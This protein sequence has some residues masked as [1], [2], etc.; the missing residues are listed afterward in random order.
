MFVSRPFLRLAAALVALAPVAP[1]AAVDKLVNTPAEK[2]VTAPGGV[3][4]RTGRFVYEEQDLSI[5]G[6]GNA[7]LSFSRTLTATV[8]G[9]INPFGNLSHN[10]DIMVS[11]R[12]FSIDNPD[13][14]SGQDF[15]INVH[16]GGRSMTY[17]A[18]PTT[19]GY[20]QMS[21]GTPAPLTFT[22]DRAGAAVYTYTAADGTVAVFRPIGTGECS[23]AR[24]CAYVSEITEVD[25]TR[26]TFAYVSAGVGMRLTRVTSSRGFALLL[27]GSGPLVTKACLLNLAVTSAPASGLCPAGVPSATYSYTGDNRIAAA[28]GPD[29]ATSSFQYG[30]AAYL[31]QMAGSSTTGFVKPGYTTPWLTN[32]SH[33]RI[34]EIGV[35]Q[36]IVDHQAYADGQTYTYQYQ[37]SPW[38]SYKEQALAG[39]TYVDALGEGGTAEYAWPI[40]PGANYPGSTCWHKPCVEPMPDGPIDD[41]S[42]VYHQTPGPVMISGQ[43][44]ATQFQFCDAAAMAGLPGNERNRCVVDPVAQYIIDQDGVRI[45]LKYDDNYNVIE[46]KRSPKPG[47]LNQDGTAPAPIVTS[48]TYVT[49]LSKAVNKPL[50]MT[51][52]RGNTSRWTYAPEHGGVRTE[53]G[54]EVNGVAPQKRYDYVQRTARLADASAAG[55]AVWLLDRM[56]T[57]RTGKPAL[58]GPG[59]ALGASD[60]VVTRY[61]YGPETGPNNLLLRGQSVTADGTTLRT[62][63]AY[64]GQGRKISE[65]SP[66]GTA[67]L[68]ACPMAAPAGPLPFTS[69]TRYDVDGKVTGT[70]APDPDGSGPLPSPAVRNS[71]D[72]AGRLIMVEEGMLAGWLPH[73]VQPSAWTGFAVLK[74][75]VSRYDALDR[76]TREWVNAGGATWSST[77]YSYDLAGR[78]KCTAVRMNPDAW[79]VPLADP[80]VHGPAHA[81]HGRDRISKNVYD[82]AGRLSEVWDGVGTPLQRREAAWTYNGHQKLSL[83]DARG[84]RAEMKYDGFGRQQRWVF[85]SKTT[86]GVADA[87]DYE[88]Y[89]Y[90][91]TG[92]RTS[93]RKRDG[94]VLTF[95]YDALNRMIAKIVP[96]RAGLTAAQTRDVHYEYDLRGLQT[97]ARFDSLAGE[98]VTTQYDGFGRST[99]STLAM[100]GTSRAIGHLYDANGNRTRITHPDGGWLAYEYDGLERFKLL[101]E[102]SGD[103]LVSFTYDAAGRRSGLASGGTASAY[104][105][106]PAGRL[107]SLSHNLAGTS[108]DQV[109]GLGYNP[110][111]QIVT[112]TGS[113]D[114]FAWN[115]AV[116]V[117]RP[118][119]VNGQNQYIAAG[120]AGFTYDANGN[121]TSDGSTT[122]VYDVENRLVSASG[123]K[124]AALVYDP[125]GRLF[126]TSGGA[127]GIAQFLYD[128]DA[129]IAEYNSAGTMLRRYVHGAGK[130]V[131]DPLLWYENLASGWR[132]ALVADQQG[133][134][135][136][137][138]DM[139]GNP[140]AFNAYDEYGV[141][142]PDQNGTP[143]AGNTGRFQYTGQAWIPEL[144]MYYYKARIYSPTLGRFLQVDPIGYDDQINLYVYVGNDPINKFDPAGTEGKSWWTSVTEWAGDAWSDLKTEARRIP[145]DLRSLPR[146]I[147]NGTTGLPP[148]VSGG[149]NIATAPIRAVNAVR[150]GLAARTAVAIER[151][152]ASI[153]VQAGKNSVTFKTVGGF[154][155]V[156]LAGKAHY[157][158]EL[159]RMVSTPHVQAFRENIV[160]GVVKSISRVGEAVPAT[161]RDLERVAEALK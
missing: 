136:A 13:S 116:A 12:K 106:D 95:Q 21:P 99:S 70:I 2:F 112:R 57:C 17:Q 4:L 140:I 86:A 158:K 53:T 78:L 160:N 138:A 73:G 148:T 94:S 16:F 24:R 14:P 56:S 26:F 71:Y 101:R 110:A 38:L 51:D 82:T 40:A 48:A 8:P 68:A 157:S 80:C 5:G 37:L 90:D 10:W 97:K 83:T 47:V 100:A 58:S 130:G 6:E 127:A 30:T 159:G 111:S 20:Q 32:R 59:C 33:V 19:I 92:N 63:Y 89:L 35:P 102:D 75:I 149:A 147:A 144:G 49:T 155:I 31:N 64:D 113:N 18:R 77:E 152:A 134:I 119:S 46:A 22:G 3:D 93:L 88:Q 131:D 122:F 36:D 146:H 156:D 107:Q 123:A 76:K 150:I 125:L 65:T 137:V 28:T 161:M 98:G 81:I 133:S 96:E 153:A 67:A 23:T 66:G 124:N 129:L 120:P 118:Y 25:G 60:E 91:V 103:P 34:D 121:L 85:P 108:G 9:H 69:S 55:P 104:G 143:G 54:P 42:F 29:N 109:I 61:E 117:D 151:R 50:S 1:A 44:I 27:E 84:Y 154:K 126:Q 43:G 141:A 74:E 142:K 139:Y 87:N 132:R 62:C 114:G 79:A 145:D 135:V 105:Y 39:G 72:S 115:G 7:G 45:D 52:A 15:Q 11:E 41:P 128:D